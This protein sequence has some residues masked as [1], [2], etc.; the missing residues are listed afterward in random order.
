MPSFCNCFDHHIHKALN[1]FI[2]GT[3]ILFHESTMQGDP[4]AKPMYAISLILVIQHLR[5]I[6][7]QVW[8]ADHAAAWVYLVSWDDLVAHMV[9]MSM[10]SCAG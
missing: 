9:I 6:A 1:L 5:S 7:K 4:L 3:S 8:Y 2:D 10:Q